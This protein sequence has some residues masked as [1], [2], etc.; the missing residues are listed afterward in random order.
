MS[1]FKHFIINSCDILYLQ[2]QKNYFVFYFN[3]LR[4]RKETNQWIFDRSIDID[5]K[6]YFLQAF[7]L[8][9][10]LI[11]ILVK[12]V[13]VC[14]LTLDMD[15]FYGL[16]IIDWH[17]LNFLV[18]KLVNVFTTINTTWSSIGI[19]L[20]YITCFNGTIAALE[21]TCII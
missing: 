15:F 12:Y 3:C 16:Y 19:A 6:L 2:I 9:F 20:W 1:I 5:I 13:Y 11:N 18:S 7:S 8:H 21:H 4:I 10:I 14:P 17:V